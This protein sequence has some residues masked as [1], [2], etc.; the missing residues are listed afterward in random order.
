MQYARSCLCWPRGCGKCGSALP[1]TSPPSDCCNCFCSTCWSKYWSWCCCPCRCF[2]CCYCLSTKLGKSFRIKKLDVRISQKLPPHYIES[3][4]W[5][6]PCPLHKTEPLSKPPLPQD[7]P[8]ASTIFPT[9]NAFVLALVFS[10]DCPKVTL[11]LCCFCCGY[12]LLC[13]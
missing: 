4:F 9:A 8:P 13:A 10:F 2:C 5:G 3:W 6:C 1:T 12:L 7:T 11:Q